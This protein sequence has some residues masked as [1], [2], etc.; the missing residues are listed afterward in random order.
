MKTKGR[1]IFR[2][3]S[4]RLG[5]TVLASISIFI[6]VLGV[7]MLVSTAD[8]LTQRLNEDIDAADLP[9]LYMFVTTSGDRTIDNDLTIDLLRNLDFVTDAE[10]RSIEP[11]SWKL[12]GQPDSA[13]NSSFLL[14]SYQ[15]FDEV[16]LM[17][18][19]ETVEGR[20]PQPGQNEIAVERR[21]ADRYGLQVGDTLTL[22][23]LGAA[24]DQPQPQDQDA[25]DTQDK[26]VQQDWTIV[27]IL[28][29]PYPTLNLGTGSGASFVPANN[30]AYVAYEDA[31]RITASRAFSQ[32]YVRYTD[33]LAGLQQQDQLL[34]TVSDDTSY[35]PAVTVNDSP[36]SSL[37]T[38]TVQQITQ[39][40][41][42]LGL[43]AMVVS[44]FLVTNVIN[45][46]MLEQKNQI[47][48]LKSLGATRLDSLQ[49]Y[50][51]V[52][53]S[54]G[55]I[56]MIPGVLLGVPLGFLMA[57]QVATQANSLIEAFTI[58]V[59]GVLLGVTMGVLVPLL[60]ATVPIIN[61][62]RVSI[63]EAMTDLGIVGNYGSGPLA[64][65]IQ[66]LPF[67]RTVKMA[68]SNV[69]RK[70]GRLLLTVLT[71]TMAI[72]AFMGVFAMVRSLN[73]WID[74]AFSSYDYQI[75]ITPNS[76][77]DY[78]QIETYITQNFADLASDVYP[79][80]NAEGI[81]PEFSNP[82]TGSAKIFSRGFETGNEAFAL[83]LVAGEGWQNDP[84]RRG[85]VLTTIQA[86]V[87]AKQVGD[88]V[89]VRFAGEENTVEL[90]GIYKS[91]S[92]HA[93][94]DWRTLAELSGSIAGA[95]IPNQYLTAA[96]V[97]GYESANST[98]GSVAV[99]GVELGGLPAAIVERVTVAA[100]ALTA[101]PPQII[102]TEG[103]AEAGA[104]AVGDDLT[105]STQHDTRTYAVADVIDVAPLL[106]LVPDELQVPADGIGMN[107]QELAALEG[108][109]LEG[110]P[111]PNQIYLQLQGDSHTLDEI[112]DAITAISEGLRTVGFSGR[113]TNAIEQAQQ[114]A[115]LGLTLGL[116][117]GLTALVMAAV[118]MVGLLATLS[119]SVYERQK[120]IGVMRS[121]GA[122]S[123]TIATQ[124]LTEGLLIGL[125]SWLLAIPVSIAINEVLKATISRLGLGDFDYPPEALL[126][127]FMGTLI[128][129]IVASL[130]P[131]LNAARKTVSEIIRY[132]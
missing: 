29:Q 119:M 51:G 21:M 33:Y 16:E 52:A 9:M 102:I 53:L 74:D 113:F 121:I 69:T 65:F 130:S 97:N 57:Q 78:R 84:D 117:F 24:A 88:L 90:I 66:R 98:D 116:I 34:Q 45:T 81:Y 60:A 59:P 43:L 114:T 10:G 107:W 32:I 115:Q 58:S 122:S 13:F 8:M 26:V 55:I 71:L 131:A 6:G 85:V 47:G 17:P 48:V 67:N 19:R 28:F 23:M 106:F 5:R 42:L 56:G 50:I 72:A 54:Y 4:S 36:Q 76:A 62:T 14:A 118:G 120:E 80:V 83:D 132:Q 44:G 101:Q 127:G 73:E 129:S 109:D 37:I 108:R 2:D 105:L 100:D 112:D 3:V 7:V 103:L 99:L 63:L 12:P 49:M 1:K 96:T 125:V 87:M 27:G 123:G 40:L 89:R 92:G 75:Q 111:A 70:K 22:R 20:F 79:G 46:I 61:G 82:Q 128:I 41:V 94:Y 77:F 68:L 86:E 25:Q 104:Y 95:P 39:V 30:T 31:Q 93:V 11:F 64:R 124:F 126:V 38:T 110:E 15:P 91:A 35:I 18:L